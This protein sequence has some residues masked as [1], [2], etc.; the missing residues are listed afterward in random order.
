MLFAL[1]GVISYK[2]KTTHPLVP[3]REGKV[4]ALKIQV[5]SPFES[6]QVYKLIN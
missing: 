4:E 2:Q 3:S 6:A 5:K 1:I